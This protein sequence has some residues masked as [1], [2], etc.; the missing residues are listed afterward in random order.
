[1][2]ATKAF[3][4]RHSLPTCFA[5]AFAISWGGLLIVLGP[6]GFTGA[7]EPTGVLLPLV[8]LAMFAGPGAAGILLT[9][10]VNGFSRVSGNFSQPRGSPH[11]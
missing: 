11:S 4:K 5:L 3:I 6:G 8:Y 10:L 9:G 1:M 7:A 2:P